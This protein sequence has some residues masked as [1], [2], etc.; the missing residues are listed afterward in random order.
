MADPELASTLLIDVRT[1]API[2]RHPRIFG[3]AAALVEG[4]SFIIVNDHDPRPLHYQ[5]EARYPGVFAWE[6][7]E[8]GPEVWRVEISRPQSSGCDC[9][10]GS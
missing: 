2:D 7:L 3:V 4:S 1:I 6:Y 8:R 5:I 9:C 10:C